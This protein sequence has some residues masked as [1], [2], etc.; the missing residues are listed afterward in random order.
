M[1]AAWHCSVSVQTRPNKRVVTRAP[2]QCLS[3]RFLHTPTHRSL[4][5]DDD[6]DTA[7]NVLETQNNHRFIS[8]RQRAR[9]QSVRRRLHDASLHVLT[10]VRLQITAWT[11]YMSF[12]GTPL[13]QG[14]RLDHQT[15]LKGGSSTQVQAELSNSPPRRVPSIN[16]I[17]LSYA[18]G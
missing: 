7:A 2:G 3:P 12:S 4:T 6:D 11:A 10:G 9:G 5:V 15:F 1:R 18:Y 17:P 13:G 8:A 14:R 16:P